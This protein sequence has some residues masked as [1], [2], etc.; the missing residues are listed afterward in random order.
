MSGDFGSGV[1]LSE[2]FDFVVNSTGDLRS[3]E[4]TQELG[5]DLAVQM[6]LNL[7]QYLGEPPSNNLN[8]R[9]ANTASNL[10]LADS[11]VRAVDKEN[12]SVSFNSS[13]DE[14]TVEMDIFTADGRQELVFTV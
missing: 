2:R 10:A 4:G 9:V 14:L 1:Y 6:A 7:D 5:K 3:A 11:R 8:A 13:R 12:I